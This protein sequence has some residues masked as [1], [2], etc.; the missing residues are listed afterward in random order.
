MKKRIYILLT[1]IINF[2]ERRRTSL[3]YTPWQEKDTHLLEQKIIEELNAIAVEH[4]SRKAE[5][6]KNLH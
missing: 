5:S 4:V 1:Q 3:N 6:N 2:L